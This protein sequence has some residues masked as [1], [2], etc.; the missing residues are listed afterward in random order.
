[1][2]KPVIIKSLATNWPAATKWK[3]P[4]GLAGQLHGT[5][6]TTLVAKDNKNF[7]LHEL[8]DITNEPIVDSI[9]NILSGSEHSRRVY[10]RLYLD[11]HPNLLGD[12]NTEHLSLLAQAGTTTSE[13]MFEFAL[14]NIGVWVSSSGCV[15]PLHYDLCHGFLCQII[16]RKS[17]LLASPDDTQYLYRNTSIVTKNQTSSKVNL[18]KWISNCSAER[19]MYPSVDEARWY[20]ADLHPGDVLYTP[21]GWWHHVTSLE[22]SVSVLLPF[23]MTGGEHLSVLQSL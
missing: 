2:Q 17:F 21:P 3:L 22:E 10:C 13:S 7:L 19:K 23:D 16:G 8:C 14:K 11:S 5:S 18:D 4:G 15:T 12:I 9:N 20:R 1:M 6:G